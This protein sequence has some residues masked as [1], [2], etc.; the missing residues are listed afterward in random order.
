[1]LPQRQGKKA[2]RIAVRR[3]SVDP[4]K[5][6]TLQVLRNEILLQALPFDVPRI[7]VGRSDENHIAI[8]SSYVS[9][10]HFMLFRHG[11]STILVDL[12]S[13]NGTFVNAKRVY[14]RVL[15]DGDVISV[16]MHSMFVQYS[17]RFFDPRRQ[18]DARQSNVEAPDEVVSRAV[19]EVAALLGKEDTDLLPALSENVP[20]EIGIIDD[21]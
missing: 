13:T 2:T 9:R 20:T 6:P 8:P 4:E 21:R 7:L 19:Q 5:L 16:D 11:D 1:M 17:I 3:A 10:H 15:V 18:P 12:N 14:S